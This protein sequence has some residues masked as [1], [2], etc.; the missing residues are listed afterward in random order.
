[1]LGGPGHH[2]LDKLVWLY[3]ACEVRRAYLAVMESEIA[4]AGQWDHLQIVEMQ[5]H[6]YIHSWDMFELGHSA[7][8][9]ED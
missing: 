5:L 3:A 6:S 4:P 7:V 8:V 2:R 9:Q 1:M